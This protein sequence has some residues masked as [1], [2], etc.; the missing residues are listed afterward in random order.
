MSLVI[1][2]ARHIDT[3]AFPLAKTARKHQEEVRE[4]TVAIVGMLVKV[5]I[6]ARL[7]SANKEGVALV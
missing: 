7:R 4:K 1:C 5:A 6:Y 2:R 3:Q